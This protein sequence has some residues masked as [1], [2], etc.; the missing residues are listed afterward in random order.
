MQATY[1]S[2][3]DS[4]SDFF[5][6]NL[7]GKATRIGSS[8]G[9]GVLVTGMLL[10]LMTSLIAMDPPEIVETKHNIMDIVMPE[11]RDIIDQQEPITEKPIEPKP[12]PVVPKITQSF[13]PQEG[14]VISMAPPQTSGPQEITGG[15][16]SGAAMAIVKV[17]PNYPRRAITRGIEG[18][19]DLMFDITPAGKTENIRVI[20]AQPKGYFEDSSLKTL[21]KWK[22][23]PAME[24]GIAMAQK[25]QTTRITYEI[26]K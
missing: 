5:Y 25:N 12:E 26:E 4:H 6:N 19:V 17:A 22:Y 15:F 10:L 16:S 24:D 13:D 20:Y 2:N 21:A 11:E 18:Y 1:F 23:K 14:E 9:L 3:L 7:L 8:A